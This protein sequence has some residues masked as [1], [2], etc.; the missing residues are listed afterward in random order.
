M[1]NDELKKRLYVSNYE[2]WKIECQQN[3]YSKKNLTVKKLEYGLILP[4]LPKKNGKLGEFSGGLCDKNFNFIDG[5]YRAKVSKVGVGIGNE[6]RSSYYCDETEINY[7]DDEVIWGGLIINHFGH[8]ILECLGKFWYILQNLS[9]KSKIAFITWSNNPVMKNNLWVK[10]IL[11]L[12]DISEDRIIIVKN[13]TRFKYIIAPEE[14]AHVWFNYTREYLSPYQ[15]MCNKIKPSEHKKLYLTRREFKEGNTLCINEKY[16]ED[17]FSQKGYLVISPEKLTIKEQISLISGADEIA[18]ILGTL[19]HWA[20]F[21]KPGTKFIMLTRDKNHTCMHQ[22]LINQA[23][24]IDWYIIDV[25][26]N[27]LY[28]EQVG[29]HLIGATNNWKKFVF[30]HFNETVIDESWKNLCFEYLCKWGQFYFSPERISY[31]NKIE[32]TLFL[33]NMYLL[34]I[35]HGLNY[36]SIQCFES[37][38]DEMLTVYEKAINNIVIFGTGVFGQKIFTMLKNT[39][40]INNMKIFFCDNDSSKWRSWGGGCDIISPKELTEHYKDSIVIISSDIYRKE[41]YNQLINLGYPRE[42][43]KR[44]TIW[45][46]I[47]DI[48]I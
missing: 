29:V 16:F 23:K 8:F 48:V 36:D 21:C 17:Y 46:T 28:S 33:E 13:P 47:E 41:M 44:I 15:Y 24:N 1:N 2:Q 42:Q 39:K 14:A 7:I 19:T 22:C 25:S 45:G 34:L 9:L 40:Y 27:F 38:F 11:N 32:P 20:L 3:Y 5:F 43:I 31:L 26:L 37:E 4:P 6:I 10:Q 12:L 30:E 35:Q 18:C